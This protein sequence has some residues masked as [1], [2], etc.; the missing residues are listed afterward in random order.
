MED[1]TIEITTFDDGYTVT[2]TKDVNELMASDPSTDLTVADD[3][4]KYDTAI[5]FA[6][7]GLV[8]AASIYAWN[9]WLKPGVKKVVNA[10]QE[11][12][13]KEDKPKTVDVESK[14]VTDEKKKEK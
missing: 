4:G 11:K 3:S 10:A 5:A 1:N 13:A 2:E 6:A 7:G 14:D 9:K 12:F 8:T